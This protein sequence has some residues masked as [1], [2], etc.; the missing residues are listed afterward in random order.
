MTAAIAIEAVAD[1]VDI[2]TVF[3][4]RCEARAMLWHDGEYELQHAVDVLQHDAE[5]DGLVKLI[6]QDAVQQIMADAFQPYRQA[7]Q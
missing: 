2:V 3:T 7:A 6:G 5:R 1:R 4:A